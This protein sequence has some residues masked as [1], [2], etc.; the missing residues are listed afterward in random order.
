M[1]KTKGVKAATKAKAIKTDQAARATAAKAPQTPR[2]TTGG[3]MKTPQQ[4]GKK[5]IVRK[6][7]VLRQKKHKTRVDDESSGLN[8]SANED[9]RLEPLN[10]LTEPSDLLRECVRAMR[11][12][13]VLMLQLLATQGE[14]TRQVPY[15]VWSAWIRGKVQTAILSQLMSDDVDAACNGSR[16]DFCMPILQAVMVKF[17]FNQGHSP[18]YSGGTRSVKGYCSSYIHNFYGRLWKP[19][20]LFM[21]DCTGMWTLYKLECK[22]DIYVY[23]YVSLPY[24]FACGYR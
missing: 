21:W 12:Q 18:L 2:V 19:L 5:R 4:R 23:P 8:M 10:S 7:G 24:W 13:N 17:K 16:E 1:G 11:K 15:E 22:V 9:D 3:D 20:S 14:Q 6:R